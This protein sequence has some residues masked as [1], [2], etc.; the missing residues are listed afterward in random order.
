M[1]RSPNILRVIKFRTL[2]LVARMR[3]GRNALKTLIAKPA[4]IDLLRRPGFKRED[5]IKMNLI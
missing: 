3:E 5:N 1:N 2:R 4:G